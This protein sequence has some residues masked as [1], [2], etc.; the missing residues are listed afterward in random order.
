MAW[1]EASM[2]KGYTRDEC[3]GFII[4]YLQKFEIVRICIWMS[5]K[6]REM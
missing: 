4:E 3:L 6:K 1:L 5:M 2:V